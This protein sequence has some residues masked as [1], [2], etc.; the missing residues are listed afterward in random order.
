M[1]EDLDPIAT[2]QTFMKVMLLESTDRH[3]HRIMMDDNVRIHS[4]PDSWTVGMV[5]KAGLAV[6][7]NDVVTDWRITLQNNSGQGERDFI[8]AVKAEN[9]EWVCSFWCSECSTL[10]WHTEL[11]YLCEECRA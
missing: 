5:G 1:N 6:E 8:V 7:E 10:V 3:G 11:H 4:L 2:T 9:L